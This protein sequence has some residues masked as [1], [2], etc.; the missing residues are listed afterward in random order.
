[1]GVR[2]YGC[3]HDVATD[4]ST[5]N[6]SAPDCLESFAL[7]WFSCVEG[8]L[9]KKTH[10][11]FLHADLINGINTRYGGVIWRDVYSDLRSVNH[12]LSNLTLP[13]LCP[14]KAVDM[15]LIVKHGLVDVLL[16]ADNKRTILDN[17]LIQR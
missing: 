13:S 9:T 14:L 12:V 10:D 16:L 17:L 3:S 6:C 11:E 1:M 7:C 8:R 2:F 5:R 15:S 4:E